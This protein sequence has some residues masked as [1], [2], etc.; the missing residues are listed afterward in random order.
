MSFGG[1]GIETKQGTPLKSIKGFRGLSV[2]IEIDTQFVNIKVEDGK[3][4]GI[5]MA[6]VTATNPIGGVP[7]SSF[8]DSGGNT[9]V[10]IEDDSPIIVRRNRFIQEYVYNNNTTQTI[11][12][13]KNLMQNP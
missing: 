6:Q 12:L 1:V 8:T 11:V 13:M 2:E 7:S 4:R 5:N 3:G 10:E 9:Q